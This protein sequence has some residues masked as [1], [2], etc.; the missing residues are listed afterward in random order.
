MELHAPTHDIHYGSA[1]LASLNVHYFSVLVLQYVQW[2]Q[3]NIG[4]Y[5]I[6][7]DEVSSNVFFP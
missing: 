2:S 1:A 5:N 7:R 4:K 6:Y 3:T